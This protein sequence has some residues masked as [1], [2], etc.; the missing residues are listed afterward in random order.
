MEGFWDIVQVAVDPRDP[1]RV[2]AA[3]WG[4]GVL[5]FRNGSFEKRYDHQN[6]PLQTALPEQ[7]QD[8]YTRIGG[9]AFDAAGQL[10]ITNAQSSKGLHTLS[11]S[12]EWK[13]FELTGVSGFQYT[14]GQ[15]IVTSADDKWII[16]PRGR[17]LY[18]VDKEGARKKQLPVTS[19][20]NNG[21][22]EIF[23]RMNDV[24]AITEDLEG[25][26]WVG[27]SRGVAV[28]ANPRRV[29]NEDNFY[30]YQPSL[31]LND[32]LYH[33]LLE[34]ETVTA[35]VVD[36]ANRKW[37]GTR[38]SGLYLVSERGTAELLHFNTDNSPLLS[39]TITSLAMHP[40]SGELFI[41]T[42]QGLISYQADAPAGR[43]NLAGVY[44]YPNPVRESY[45]GEITVAGLMKDTDVHITDIAG[46]LVFKTTSLGS[47]V[48]WDGRNLNGRRV[49]TGV[50]LVFCA[51]ATG[52]ET[53]MAKLLF[54]R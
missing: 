16:L 39:N 35:I 10:W 13:S 2:Y 27:T 42:D 17:D 19:Y 46:N 32:G 28:F 9:I 25:E 15:L 37:L 30:A 33:P 20:F 34:K 23:N 5:E 18:V 6:S 44:V 40:V 48:T 12:G 54:I 53:Q 43:E 7:P 26:I 36:G 29:W 14:I 52:N 51:D 8:P 11:P 22:Q 31:E 21:E 47:K 45:H 3:S 50:Y 41:G 1:G 38:N 49:A 4:G 24:Y